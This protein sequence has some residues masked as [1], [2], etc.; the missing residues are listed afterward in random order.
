M[1]REIPS[2]CVFGRSSYMLDTRC[3]DPVGVPQMLFL[4]IK[5]FVGWIP[6]MFDCVV[7]QCWLKFVG[8]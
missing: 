1:F 7:S 8:Y 4:S 5:H 6:S 3:E 2:N